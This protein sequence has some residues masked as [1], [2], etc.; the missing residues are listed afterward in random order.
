MQTSGAKIYVVLL[1]MLSIAVTA[2]ILGP[3][4]RGELVAINT[5]VTTFATFAYLSL[6][7]VALHRAAQ[8][9][10]NGW[11]PSTYHTLIFFAGVLTLIAWGVAGTMYASPL[12]TVFGNIAPTWLLIGFLLVPFRIWEHYGSSLLQAIQRLDIHNRYQIIGSSIGFLSTMGLLLVLGWGLEGVLAS[13]LLGQII[14]AAGGLT[15]L[16]RMAGGW[17]IPKREMMQ[18]Y[19]NNGLKLHMNAI[20]MFFITGSDILMLNYYRGSEE[21]AY[22]QL[23]VQLIG[24]LML[25]P[26]A[27]NMVVNGL[28]SSLGPNK[29]WPVHRKI[30]LQ[31][32][33]LVV[34]GALVAG[35]SVEWWLPL[36]VGEAFKPS[37]DIFQWLL[38]ASVGMTFSTLMAPQWIGRGFFGAVS[39][40][41]LVF[42]GI[43]LLLNW[44]LI[45]VSG[46]Y[47]ALTATLITF[48]ISVMVNGGMVVYCNQKSGKYEYN[49]HK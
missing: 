14:I 15:V 22:Y 19:L 38:L 34:G 17:V 43:N 32:M 23:G 49:R 26:Q 30:L 3:E 36:I 29:A 7:Q 1:G 41:A 2:R 46:M 42:G 39:V 12:K 33:L 4:G 40:L 20:G 31:V 8:T 9:D 48:S 37:I 24:I 21:T 13:N 35:L 10:G 44:I 18:H 47:G 11:F 6:G 16:H 5:W 25:I 27:A 45:P 28:V